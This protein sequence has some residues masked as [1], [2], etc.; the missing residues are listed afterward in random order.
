MADSA[1][2]PRVR[3]FRCAVCKTPIVAG[4]IHSCTQCGRCGALFGSASISAHR[5][6]PYYDDDVEAAMVADLN[7]RIAEA[8]DK[9]DDLRYQ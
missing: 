2:M 7:R 4:E 5:C 8:A 3:R 6:E 9:S 1:A